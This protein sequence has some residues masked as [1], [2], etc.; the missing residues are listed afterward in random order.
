MK[1]SRQLKKGVS[2]LKTGSMEKI[3]I[4]T[5]LNKTNKI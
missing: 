3:D 5:Y 2:K 4:G 1:L